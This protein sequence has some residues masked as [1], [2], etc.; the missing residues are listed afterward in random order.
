LALGFLALAGRSED[1]RISLP[2]DLAARLADA[3]DHLTEAGASVAADGSLT[4]SRAA[5][6]ELL[7][8][9]IDEVGEQVGIAA[10]ALLRG[11]VDAAELRAALAE[12]GALLDLL[13]SL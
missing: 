12:A 5:V 11:E 7:A 9:A 6:R 1:V 4:G 3:A 8:V 10:T 2:P 13:E